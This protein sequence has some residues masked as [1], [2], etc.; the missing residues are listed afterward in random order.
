MGYLLGVLAIAVGIPLSIALHEIGHLYGLG[1]SA[2]G[3]TELL[4][5]GGR[6]VI[7]AESVMFPIAFSAGNI[8]ARTLKAD[9]IAGISELYPSG[10]YLVDTGTIAGRVT[11]NGQGVYGAHVV[12]FNQA[13]GALVG[14]LTLDKEGRFA[15]SGLSPGPHVLRVEPLDDVSLDSFFDDTSAV[16]I[17]FRVTFLRRYAVAP[18]GGASNSVVVPVTPK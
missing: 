11:K 7:A 13:T 15:I 5:G 8:A 14:G 2:L 17:D 4:A 12:A 3:E 10:S 9:D 1:H 16:D 6:R 18:A